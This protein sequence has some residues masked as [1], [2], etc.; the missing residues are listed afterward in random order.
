MAFFVF[1]YI[2]DSQLGFMAIYHLHLRIVSL[3]YLEDETAY[4]ESHSAKRCRCHYVSELET[5][6]ESI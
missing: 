1:H 5:V 6:K 4:Q 2:S 3:L